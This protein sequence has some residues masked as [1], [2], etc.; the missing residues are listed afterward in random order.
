MSA[1]VKGFLDDVKSLRFSTVIDKNRSLRWG[2]DFRKKDPV[3]IDA[4]T[5][6][7]NRIRLFKENQEQLK[8]G[9]I[10]TVKISD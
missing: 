10:E 2:G 1:N 4:P 5:S 8:S 6:D 3:H 9:K 7:K